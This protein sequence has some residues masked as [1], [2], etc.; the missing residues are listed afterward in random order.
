MVGE[1]SSVVLVLRSSASDCAQVPSQRLRCGA[2]QRQGR[3]QTELRPLGS[4]LCY[5]RTLRRRLNHPLPN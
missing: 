2:A 3:E 5:T 4:A 1:T